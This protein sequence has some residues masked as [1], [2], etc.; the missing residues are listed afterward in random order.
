M[1]GIAAAT[2]AVHVSITRMPAR[3]HSIAPHFDGNALN[4]RLYFEEVELLSIDAGLN[5]EGKIRHALRYTSREDNELWSTLPEAEAQAPDYARFRDAV[6]KLYPGADDERKYAES[7]LEWLI[8][9]QRQYRI[10]SRAE[11]GHY[12]REFRRI[13]KFLI[14]KR[15]LSDIEH[16]KMYM[17]GFDERLR[18]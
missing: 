11:L 3:G 12:Y 16:N 9:T 14:D 6:V 10:E 5:E 1:S 7:D 2:P 15:R 8:N 17:R 18:E 13:S 4:L